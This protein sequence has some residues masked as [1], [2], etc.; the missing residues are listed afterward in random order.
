MR[1]AIMQRR[2]TGIV[3]ILLSLITA[4][5]PMSNLA[6]A[7]KS[8]VTP[9]NRGAM[10]R[11]PKGGSSKT[12][13]V[14]FSSRLLDKRPAQEQ[15]QASIAGQTTTRLSDGRLLR[16][17]GLELPGPA[18][19]VTFEDPR[20]SRRTST[21]EVRM[22]RVRAFHSATM[23]PNGRVLIVG[24]ISGDGK[25]A[26]TPEIFDPETQTS[27]LLDSS[28][29]FSIV[30]PRFAIAARVYHTAT[31][32]TEGLV[33]IAGGLSG[34]GD[35]TRTAEIW[36]FRTKQVTKRLKLSTAR[37]GQTSRLLADGRVLLSGG[38][39]KKGARLETG[40]IF[41]P[42]RMNLS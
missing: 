10:G 9:L 21:D 40:E 16:L 14:S 28:T 41:D 3:A 20:T 18:A 7:Q 31:L 35:A 24:G 32:M 29:P 17:G 26:D 33:L 37:Y 19:T 5:G 38:S 42:A 8:S 2:I 30:K 23:L 15:A 39:D 1:R 11:G 22:Q 34:D 12:A 4:L 27:E 6:A 36:D 13:G 25:I